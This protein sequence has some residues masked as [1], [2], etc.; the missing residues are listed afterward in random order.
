VRQGGT[1]RCVSENRG[2]DDLFIV[3]GGE[4]ELLGFVYDT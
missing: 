3:V 2:E 1:V 4:F